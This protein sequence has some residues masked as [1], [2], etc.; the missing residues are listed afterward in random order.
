MSKALTGRTFQR[1]RNVLH[2]CL[3]HKLSALFLCT[4]DSVWDSVSHTFCQNCQNLNWV[5]PNIKMQ[6]EVLLSI[7]GLKKFFN[8]IWKWIKIIIVYCVSTSKVKIKKK[9][10]II[11]RYILLIIILNELVFIILLPY[12]QRRLLVALTGR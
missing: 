1:L 11:Y 5:H 6:V 7:L 10:L 4:W 9:R 12:Y 3:K 8:L 2:L